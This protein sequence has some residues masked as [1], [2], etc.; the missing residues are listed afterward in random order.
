MTVQHIG[1]V[2]AADGGLEANEKHL[3]GAYCNHTDAHGYC[4]PGID[5]LI[6]ETGMSRSTVKRVN[7]ALKAKNLIKSVR[8]INPVT[9]EPISNLTRVNVPLLE[10]MKRSK[11]DYNDN[12]I[13]AITFDDEEIAE[14]APDNE[15][16][17]EEEKA[18]P[19][20]ASD[21]LMVQSEPY[22]G[23]DWTLGQGHSEP[24][25]GFNLNPKTS[26]EPSVETSPPSPP[27]GVSS[28]QS[29]A[30]EH[31]EGEEDAFSTST[32]APSAD[33][34]VVRSSA[35][36][37]EQGEISETLVLDGRR[38]AAVELVLSLPWQTQPSATKRDRL[39]DLV[40]AAWTAGWT[41]DALRRELVMEL[42][43]ARSLY[44]V[45]ASRLKDLPAPRSAQ[46]ARPALPPRCSDSRHD[47]YMPADRILYD[48][49]AGPFPCPQCHPSA[50]ARRN[51]Q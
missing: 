49:D 20:S 21:L 34:D 33:E 50:I 36:R 9:G 15:E 29:Q 16:T 42:D 48:D 37:A 7:K 44:A 1:M 3:L 24:D 30:E 17:S 51:A 39:A 2:Y 46:A 38:A 12:L 14:E 11:R 23:S 18:A 41:S 4:W 8:R 35:L 22:P 19:E 43:G 13:E 5:R 47:P 26:V 10:S 45:W 32:P 40:D 6:D 25:L 27:S 28:Q 31:N